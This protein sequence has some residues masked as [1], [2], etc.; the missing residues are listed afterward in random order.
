MGLL[1]AELAATTNSA[2][3]LNP[4]L[5]I[6]SCCEKFVV[7]VAS[8]FTNLRERITLQPLLC[9][10]SDVQLL[11]LHFLNCQVEITAPE[12]VASKCPLKS[13]RFFASKEFPVGRGQIGYKNI[14]TP[15]WYVLHLQ[16][17]TSS[18]FFFLRKNRNSRLNYL[19]RMFLEVRVVCVFKLKA[20][21]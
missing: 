8:V 5:Q 21:N 19:P 11:W 16:L 17:Q 15:W 4:F 2:I 9:L 12:S 18:H 3:L 7:V 1:L 13:F 20:K 14:R 10:V 6:V